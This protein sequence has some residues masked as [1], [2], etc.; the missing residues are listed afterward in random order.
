M[1]RTIMLKKKYEFKNLFSKGTFY[2]GEY[3]NMYIQ[4]TNNNYNKL[5]I[6]IF[7]KQGK[8]VVRNHFKRLVKENYKNLEINL[9]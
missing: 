4:K 8:A 6:A 3:I 2:G 1:K 5:G 9:K 7:K